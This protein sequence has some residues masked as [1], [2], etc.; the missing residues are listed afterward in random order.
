MEPFYR[1]F[2]FWSFL[3]FFGH[4]LSVINSDLMIKAGPRRTDSFSIL[5]EFKWEAYIFSR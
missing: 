2:F 1:N 5:N 4:P 3:N